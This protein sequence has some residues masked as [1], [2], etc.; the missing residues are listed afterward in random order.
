MR[1]ETET[2]YPGIRQSW[3]IAGICILSIVLLIPVSICLENPSN[4][5]PLPSSDNPAA[6]MQVTT[7][8]HSLHGD[9]DK[10]KQKR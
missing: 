2:S 6:P 10:D 8:P 1:E 4:P 5:P 7:L 3:G 9:G